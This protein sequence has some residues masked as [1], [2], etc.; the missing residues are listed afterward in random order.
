[1]MLANPLTKTLRDRLGGGLIAAVSVAAMVLFTLWTYQDVDTSF[2]YELPPAVLE[3]MGIDPDGSGLGGMAFGSMYDFIAAIVVAGIAISIGA[4]AIAGEERDGT[5]GLLLGNPL[6]RRGVLLSK[7]ASMLLIVAVMGGVLYLGAIVS[8][9]WMGTDTRGLHLGAISL[10]LTVNALFYGML[11]QAI[12]A[13]TGK[14]SVASAT[15]S[16]LMIIGFLLASLLPLMEMEGLA[17]IFPWYYYNSSSPLNNGLH[18]GHLAVLVGLT[19]LSFVAGWLGIERRDLR[20]KGTDVTLVDRLRANPRTQKAMDRLAGSTRVS[21]IAVKTTSDFQSLATITAGIVFYMGLWIPILFNF[22]P[23]D[24]VEI[25]AS[26][27][28]ALIAMIGGVDMSTATGFITG[29]I[30]SLTAPIAIIVLMNSM[31]S[32][33]LAGEEESHTMGLLLGNPISRTRVVMEK[34]VSMVVYALT[35]AVVTSVGVYLGVLIGGQDE[36]T[37]GGIVAISAL[38]S[39]FGLVFGGIAMAISA[40][41]GKTRLANWVTTSVAIATWFMFSYLSLSETTAPL[42][43]LSPFHWFLGSDPLLNGMDWLGA[44]L[45]LTT[46]VSLVLVSVPLFNRRDLRG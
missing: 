2:Y 19:T 35:F 15:A 41:T 5:F 25:F 3:V 22:I 17:K 45:M 40:A 30:F 28:D 29:E 39:L 31:G 8:A 10:A 9:A 33:A 36:V 27:P 32:K 37:I 12:G 7:T 38:L 26:F 20:E 42:V 4:S 46:F 14:R 24:F 6:S 18:G 23:E 13:W 11:A 44:T 43:E 34:V 1:M 16:G 21:R